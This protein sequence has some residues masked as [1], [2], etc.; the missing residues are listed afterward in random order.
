MLFAGYID[1]PADIPAGDAADADHHALSRRACRRR[2]AVLRRAQRARALLRRRR[3]AHPAQPL[4][5]GR[6]SGSFTPRPDAG[7]AMRPTVAVTVS[8]VLQA[9]WVWWGAR[10]LRREARLPLPRLTPGREALARRSPCPAP[11]AG[12]ALQI[13][14]LVSQA[15]ASFEQ[16]AITCAQRCRP[17][18][19]VAA[20]PDRRRRRRGDAAAAVAAGAGRRPAGRARRAGRGRRAL[21]GVHAA[22][23]GGAAGDARSS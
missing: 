20:R 13:N 3:R 7:G 10:A 5:A 4:P 19:P 8:G 18:L 1:D 21:H 9:L 2:D 11:I 12:G 17:A 16:G 23:G 22:G 14:V 6:A 15:L